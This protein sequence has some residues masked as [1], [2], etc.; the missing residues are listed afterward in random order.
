MEPAALKDGTA[1]E[2]QSEPS[3]DDP[4]GAG[5][6]AEEDSVQYGRVKEQRSCF[7]SHT[8]EGRLPFSSTHRDKQGCNL[9]AS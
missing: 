4:K 1:P 5:L 8:L 7:R 3:L 9:P 6:A 2:A